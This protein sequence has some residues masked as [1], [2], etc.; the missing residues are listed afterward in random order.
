MRR[1][2]T[3][4]RHVLTQDA[5]GYPPQLL[6]APD[7]PAA[8]YVLGNVAALAEGLAVVGA[9]DAT[10][11]GLGCA[12]RFARAAAQRGVVIISGGARGCDAAAH[13]GALEVG[14]RTVVVCGGGCDVVYPAAHAPLFRRVLD[15]GGALVS[16]HPWGTRPEPYMFR[17]R[18]KIIAGLA[19]ATL[20]VEAGLPSGTF[21]TADAALAAGRE[22]WAIPGTITSPKSKGTNR[23][24][25]QGAM[26]IIDDESFEDTLFNTFGVMRMTKCGDGARGAGGVSVAAN[27]LES[28]EFAPL[29]HALLAEPM[30]LEALNALALARFPHKS[31]DEC[32]R[33]VMSGLAEAERFHIVI[34]YGDGRI[35]ARVGGAG[36]RIC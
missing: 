30:S 24:I 13:N 6:C 16:A 22:V 20:I 18:N 33:L 2:L 25:A 4:T 1:E 34:R 23:L 32:R 35:G 27:S 14:E 10:P 29:L 9:R 15:G 28:V 21:S 8:L 19:R 17:N 5:A 7:A 31:A 26:P 11:Y 12:Q 36:V 3:G